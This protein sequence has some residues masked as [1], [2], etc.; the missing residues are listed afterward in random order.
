MEEVEICV[1]GQMDASWSGWLGGLTVTPMPQGKTVLSGVVRDQSALV[2]L[3]NKL[4]GLGLPLVSLTTA[5][6][7]TGGKEVQTM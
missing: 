1:K 2:G 5:R 3:L 7:G 6:A 4:S